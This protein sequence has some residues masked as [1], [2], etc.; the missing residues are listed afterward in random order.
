MDFVLSRLIHLSRIDAFFTTFS[1]YC[2]I[3][4]DKWSCSCVWWHCMF[5]CLA[6]VLAL[7]WLMQIQTVYHC[8]HCEVEWCYL[9]RH[10][11]SVVI[12][13]TTK[14]HTLVCICWWYNKLEPLLIYALLVRICLCASNVVIAIVENISVLLA[15]IVGW[16][17]SFVRCSR[18]D[19]FC[20]SFTWQHLSL[21]T[22]ARL[23]AFYWE[24]HGKSVPETRFYKSWQH[25]R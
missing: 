24:S 25:C 11:W 2:V 18:C 12:S 10:C 6:T 22:Y 19:R 23:V 9:N 3:H 5:W 21:C 14:P 8:S 17:G 7:F 1:V 4:A 20:M 13:L 16:S 15:I